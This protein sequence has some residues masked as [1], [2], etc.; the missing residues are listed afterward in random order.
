MTNLTRVDAAQT[1]GLDITPMFKRWLA[2]LVDIINEDLALTE[3]LMNG[4]MGV[5]TLVAGTAT[6]TT[7]LVHTGNT[8]N[9]SEIQF[10][11]A[12]PPG[13]GTLTYTI[14]DGVSFTITSTNLTETSTI[15]WTIIAG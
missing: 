9:L 11:G 12:N 3:K 10:V 2:N 6:V 15:S 7:P 8:I 1:E 14:I 5:V 13:P 4:Y